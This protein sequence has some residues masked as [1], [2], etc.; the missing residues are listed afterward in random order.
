MKRIEKP[1]IS[2]AAICG[3]WI[4]LLESH[5]QGPG[6]LIVFSAV[7]VIVAIFT[8]WYLL[9]AFRDM[10]LDGRFGRSGRKRET[11]IVSEPGQ[12]IIFDA[13]M[14]PGISRSMNPRHDFAGMDANRFY[15]AMENMNRP[16]PILPVIMKSQRT[17]ITGAQDTGKSTLIRHV[18]STAVELGYR[19]VCLDFHNF[20]PGPGNG[21]QGKYPEGCEVFGTGGDIPGMNHG[22]KM[23]IDLIDSRYSE[24]SRGLVRERGHDPV[25][26]VVDE[27]TELSEMIPELQ[28]SFKFKMMTRARKATVDYLEAGQSKTA[29]S[30]GTRGRHDINRFD[31]DVELSK[32]GSERSAKGSFDGRNWSGYFLPGPLGNPT[33][34]IPALAYLP[35]SYTG[36][37]YTDTPQCNEAYTELTP[38][39][40]V[41]GYRRQGHS[42]S[43]IC[44]LV[45]GSKGGNQ[46]RKVK[47]ILEEYEGELR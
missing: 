42:L 25:Y 8:G 3:I 30:S 20:N 6:I 13:G 41:I 22:I 2:S 5:T 7:T 23:I 34:K 27:M 24:F 21:Y 46:I 37:D 29:R 45:F 16:A 9:E 1:V 14:N 12:T 36:C 10:A 44:K 11:S 31:L 43:K 32:S 15:P 18:C 28:K 33:R 38:A 39:E 35:D 47:S 19:V 26:V 4:Y 40:Q 17:R